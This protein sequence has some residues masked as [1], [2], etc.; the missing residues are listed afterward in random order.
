MAITR[1]KYDAM[2]R[3]SSIENGE[4]ITYEYD[5]YGQLVEEVN[6]TLDKTFQY[7]YNGIGNLESVTTFSHVK[8][9]PSTNGTT[10]SFGY[11]TTM[12][13]H[14]RHTTHQHGLVELLLDY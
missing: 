4:E 12:V 5:N 7:E 11:D 14:H 8:G 2:G 1:Y 6:N 10:V 13:E 3:I 9:V